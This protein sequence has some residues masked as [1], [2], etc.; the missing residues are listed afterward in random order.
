M[1]SQSVAYLFRHVAKADPDPVEPPAS[2][3]LTD[4]LAPFLFGVLPT[5]SNVSV[6]PK[7]A[8][9]VPAVAAAV[10]LIANAVGTL[11]VKIFK[12]GTEG[13]K[14]VARDHATYALAHDDANEF[15]S[16][17]ALR[18]QLTVDALL[19]GNGFAFAN[20]VNEMPVELIRLDPKA[21]TVKA[22]PTTGEPIYSIGSGKAKRTFPY[23]DIIHIKPFSLDGLT[24][25]API[26][27]GREGIALALALEQH[28]ARLFGRGA[29][30]S[31]VLKHPGK[32]GAEGAKRL[33]EGWQATQAGEN[34]GGTALLE[35]GLDFLPLTFNSVDA[36]F[37]QM[38]E[39]QIKEVGRIF[40]V[41]TTFL[42]S[43]DRATFKNAEEM[44]LQFMRFTL[45]PWLRE[46]E[47]AYRRV[48]LTPEER[49][50]FTV[51]FIVDDL[52]RAD[53]AT[54][55]EGFS[56]AI[57][58][59]ILNPNEVR[60]LENRPPYA[61][62]ETYGNPYTTTAAPPSANNDNPQSEKDAA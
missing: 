34:T 61:G 41:P 24:G 5:L 19:H 18:T 54:R 55:M 8:M 56:K 25:I 7:S 33:R 40:S 22:D 57:A 52:L 43:L 45:L 20:R 60:A 31:G 27:Q 49:T 37:E 15:T 21:M 58:A 39:M 38:R 36:Q 10:R 47:A 2:V 62:G 50:T 48:L 53:F 46:W 1:L 3:S 9:T 12:R 26:E 29:R 6:T 16:A 28:A 59:R 44:N 14:E 4:P 11:P 30:P 13:S 32:L 42:G 35:E 51:E 23:S 17:T